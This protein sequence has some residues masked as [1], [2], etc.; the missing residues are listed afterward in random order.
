ME[1]L[2]NMIV[3]AADLVEAEGRELRRQFLRA[4]VA[5][6]AGIVGLLMTLLGLGFLMLGL[7]RLLARE[8][9]E[10]AAAG[11]FGLVALI[12]AAG[13]IWLTQR[14]LK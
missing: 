10:P 7:Y 11:I 4:T 1:A 2:A 3:A 12:I 14:L 6:A 13:A 8:L 5:V 9:S